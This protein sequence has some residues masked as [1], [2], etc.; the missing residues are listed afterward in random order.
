MQL[1]CRS[2]ARSK[3]LRCVGAVLSLGVGCGDSPRLEWMPGAA[4][5]T[6]NDVTA[7]TGGV[8]AGEGG[9]RS[10]DDST[11]VAGTSG[12]LPRMPG[13]AGS[14]TG[15]S[16]STA[17]GLPPT[18]L[19]RYHD[20]ALEPALHFELDA[21]EGLEPYPASLDHLTD[22]MGRVLGKPDGVFFDADETLAPFGTDH[23][24]TFT[25][26]ADY[27]REHA[28]DDAH[29]PITIHVLLVDGRYQSEDDSGTVLGLAWGQRY[30]A[31]FQD[32]LR[33]EC[34]GG[35]LGGLQTQACE[36]AERSV[37]AH[38]IGHVI[39]L[40]D[41]GLG[42][43][44]P[45]RDAAHGRHDVSTDCLMYWAYERPAIFDTLLGR[46]N[47]GQNADIDFCEN[48]WADLNAAR[49]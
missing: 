10:V 28:R 13:V 9:S 2:R 25:E 1:R 7:G 34:S 11:A 6:P 16:G 27:S 37:W 20:T 49:R 31:L 32:A 4:G 42:Q 33:S 30:I 35:L 12:T 36:I 47:S 39:G 46:L 48:C 8:A 38:E 29:G 17:T 22:L 18:R 21:V 26:L 40:V 5:A 41:N 45:H 14:A 15:G 23:V 3:S 43:Q 19:A 44:T 24:W